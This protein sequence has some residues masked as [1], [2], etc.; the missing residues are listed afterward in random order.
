MPISLSRLQPR[1]LFIAGVLLAVVAYWGG[2]AELVSRWTS[3]E[4]YSHGFLIPFISLWL[5]WLRRDALKGQLGKTVL[6]V[7]SDHR[8]GAWHAP[9]G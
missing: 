9:P 1:L 5:L 4:E 6:V 3:Q 8:A 7:D 2:L